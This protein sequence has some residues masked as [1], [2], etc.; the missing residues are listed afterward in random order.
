MEKYVIEYSVLQKAFHIHTMT[1]ML[2]KNLM[3]VMAEKETDYIPIMIK[4]TRD[5]AEKY[6]LH[7]EKLLTQLYHNHKLQRENS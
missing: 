3:N 7:V 5:E 2:E 1:E 6:V 4:G